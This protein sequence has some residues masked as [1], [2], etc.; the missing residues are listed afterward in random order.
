M[1]KIDPRFLILMAFC[2]LEKANIHELLEFT[3]MPIATFRRSLASLRTDLAMDIEYV[4]GP[5]P[6]IPG[7]YYIKDWGVIDREKFYRKYLVESE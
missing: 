6:R 4:R 5:R 2:E 1:E 3:K 7:Y